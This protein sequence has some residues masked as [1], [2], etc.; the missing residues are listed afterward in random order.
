VRRCWRVVACVYFF[1]QIWLWKFKIHTD[2]EWTSPS[3][4]QVLIDMGLVSPS[5]DVL[6]EGGPYDE[7]PWALL[8]WL[9]G[10]SPQ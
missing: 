9:A 8:G 10:S 1:T 3:R 6:Y 4:G 2:V 5:G 7:P